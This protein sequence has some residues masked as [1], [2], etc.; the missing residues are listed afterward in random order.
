MD[1]TVVTVTDAARRYITD[2]CDNGKYLVSIKVNN[3]GCSGHSYEYGLVDPHAVDKFDEVI[4]WTNGGIAI[5]ASSVMYLIGSTLDLKTDIMEN[6]LIWENP[7]VADI[8]G[9]GTSFGFRTE[10]CDS[11]SSIK[12]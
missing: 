3:K 11:G 5:C 6:Y 9:C 4:K 2:R 1:T 12:E 8:C 7:H 10:S